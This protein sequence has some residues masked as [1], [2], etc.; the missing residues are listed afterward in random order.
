MTHKC[1][2]INEGA[3]LKGSVA[4][5]QAFVVEPDDIHK[6]I[7]AVAETDECRHGRAAGLLTSPHFMRIFT[8]T[9]NL[10]LEISESHMHSVQKIK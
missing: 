1:V 3:R 7:G 6:A 10:M 2:D 4:Y 9:Q 8:H 5:T